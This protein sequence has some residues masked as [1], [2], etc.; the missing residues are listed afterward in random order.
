VHRR[1]RAAET[2]IVEVDV[3]EA[4]ALPRKRANTLALGHVTKSAI[5]PRCMCGKLLDRYVH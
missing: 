2:D 1:K 4:D 5:E 3:V